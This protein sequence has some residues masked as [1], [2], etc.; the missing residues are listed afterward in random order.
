MNL[1]LKATAIH[2]LASAMIALAAW[3]VVF[4]VWFP[5]PLDLIAGGASLFLLLMTVDVVL[6]PVLTAVVA[7]PL[8]GRRELTRDI[9]VIAVI[10]V[11]ALIYGMHA[12]AAGR[13]V[14]IAFELDLFRLVSANEV[15]V[16]Q[17]G[18]APEHLQKLSWTGPLT[19]ATAKP[20]TEN[21]QMETL[22]LGLAGI[23]LAALPRYWRSYDAEAPKAWALAQPID[24]LLQAHPAERQAIQSLAQTAKVDVADL[25][26]LP[27]MARRAEGTVLLAPPDARVVGILPVALP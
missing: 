3:V 10:Q 11:A 19:L 7:N 22:D 14:A 26:V 8:K 24:I 13:P 25:R 12:V 5:P 6:G 17:L 20:L 2:L 4:R 27:L 1:R 15:E 21:E 9:C 23:H 16:S 18:E